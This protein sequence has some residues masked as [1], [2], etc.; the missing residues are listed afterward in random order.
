VEIATAVSIGCERAKLVDTGNREIAAAVLK[1]IVAKCTET[2]SSDKSL[3][4]PQLG[5]RGRRVVSDDIGLSRR[6]GHDEEVEVI[7]HVVDFAHTTTGNY[8]LV[9]P[10][11]HPELPDMA[12]LFGLKNLYESLETIYEEERGRRIKRSPR[13]EKQAVSA[14]TEAVLE[15]L[16]LPLPLHPRFLG[17]SLT[18]IFTHFQG[19]L[20]TIFPESDDFG[21]LPS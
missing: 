12:F 13:L 3:L 16:F 20:S 17:T 15:S 4:P 5:P 6:R 8:Y 2:S 11:H 10:P 19:D 18:T 14:A 21:M 9:Y 1:Q 7:I